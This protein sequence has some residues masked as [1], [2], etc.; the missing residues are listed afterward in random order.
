MSCK[1]DCCIAFR[2]PFTLQQ[3]ANGDVGEKDA[4][5]AMVMADMLVPL[6]VGEANARQLRLI[7]GEL[8]PFS[9]A[10]EGHL[11]MCRHWDEETRLCTIY[12]DRPAMCRDFPYG[13]SC[14]YGCGECGC[15]PD[16]KVII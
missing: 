5:E 1:G 4:E 8:T 13:E 15:K 14:R 7:E 16:P 9:I 10:D 6:T 2:V 11:F 3:L 12:E